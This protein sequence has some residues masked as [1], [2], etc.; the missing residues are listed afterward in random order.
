MNISYILD[1]APELSSDINYL[2]ELCLNIGQK[3][4]ENKNVQDLLNDPK[5]TFDVVIS[6]YIEIEVNAG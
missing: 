5:E 2:Q 1:E 4:F 3:T 6:D